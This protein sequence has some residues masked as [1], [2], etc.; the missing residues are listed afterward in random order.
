MAT[1]PSA[2]TTQTSRRRAAYAD[3]DVDRPLVEALRRRGFDVLTAAEAGMLGQGDDT[4]LVYA[5]SLNRIIVSY[6]RADF[7]TWHARFVHTGR[8][9]A[10][11][12]LLPQDS[13]LER[14]VVR[15]ALLLDWIADLGD[16]APALANWNDLQQALHSGYRVPGY[17]E[18]ETLIA[19]GQRNTPP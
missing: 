8:S 5:A 16:R 19:L 18:A 10:G 1:S 3:E 15:A 9:H 13:P 6:N 14:R 4:Q 7:R 12:V 2:A 17:V 11:I